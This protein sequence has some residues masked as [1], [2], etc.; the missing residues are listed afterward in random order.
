MQAW[1]QLYSVTSG[2]AATLLGLLF[3]AVSINASTALGEMHQNSRR[4]AEQAFQN[5]LIVMLVSLLALFPSL[6]QSDLGY[7]TLGLSALRSVWAVVRLYWA[8]KEPYDV[9]SRMKSLRRQLP[10]LIGFALLIYAALCMA[11]GAGDTRTTFAIATVT[12]LFSATTLA[13]EL[14]LRIA[15]QKRQ[16]P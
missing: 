2:S 1:S 13:W 12:L 9:E 4:L 16:Q 14:L 8:A 3:V 5:Y 11:R 10:S 7:V 15:V 6:E